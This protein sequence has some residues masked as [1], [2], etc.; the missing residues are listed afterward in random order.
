LN[1]AEPAPQLTAAIRAAPFT[2]GT[3]DEW[4]KFGAFKV[5]LDG[6]MI[7]GT[8]YQRFPY[9]PFG[10]QLYGE[11]NPDSRGQLFIEPDKLYAILE[12]A[13]DKGWQMTAHSQGG[14]AVDNLLDAFEKLNRTRPIGPSRSHVMHASFQHPDSIRRA[15]RI[16]VL[17]DVQP[18]W[19]YNDAPALEKVVGHASM[20]YFIPLRTYFDEGIAPAGGSDHMIGHDLNKAINPF[21]PFQAMWVA[22]TRRMRNGEVLYP[23][24]RITRLEALRMYTTAGAYMQFGEKDKGTLEPG[25]FAD[26]VV[27]DRDFLNC[28]EDQIKEIRPVTVL[29]G[30]K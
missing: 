21:N 14:G 17:A 20:R 4:L 9:G 7:Q 24:E 12:A 10:R 26:L 1:A 28:P 25:K 5:T 6:G 18:A 2:T 22:I 23:E 15:K 11:T 27:I 16:G 8:A 13:R 30:G 3:G 19:L 29:I